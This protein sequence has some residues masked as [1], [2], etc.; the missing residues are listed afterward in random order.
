MDK[1]FTVDWQAAFVPT[2]PL[3]EIVLRGTVM[4]LFL[5]ALLRLMKR[6][7]G[8]VGL[9]DLLLVVVIADAAQN[10]M[11]S[12]YKS[13]TEGAV[14]VSTLVFWNYALDWLGDRFPRIQRL[15]HPPPVCLVKDGKM[16]RRN[17]RQEL[18]SE[19]ELMSQLRLQGAKELSEVKEARLEGN[20]EISVVKAS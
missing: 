14:L 4:Y 3:A 20:G 10:A 11:A 2:V 13:I 15:L 7:S 9:A 17:M 5:F 6:G 19:D 12:E 18:V 1:L 8:K 16:L